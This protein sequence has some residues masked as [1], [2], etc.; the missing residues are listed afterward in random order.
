MVI[1]WDNKIK[2]RLRLYCVSFIPRRDLQF[3]VNTINKSE[4]IKLAYETFQKNYSDNADYTFDDFAEVSAAE[5][6]N[7]DFLAEIINRSVVDIYDKENKV[8]ALEVNW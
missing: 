2:E 5:E 4:A 6:I 3:V 8:I 1:K 7:M